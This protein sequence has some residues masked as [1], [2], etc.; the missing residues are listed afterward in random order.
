MGER[1][2]KTVMEWRGPLTDEVLAGHTTSPTTVDWDGDG[3]RDLLIG[4]EDGFL[5]L[6]KS[7]SAQA[8]H[9]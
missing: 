7:P 9:D 4:A 6:M 2:G 5:Y 8:S 3:H 1:D